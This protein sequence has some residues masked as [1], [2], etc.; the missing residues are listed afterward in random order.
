MKEKAGKCNSG[1]SVLALSP[2]RELAAQTA[3]VL[4]QL[5]PD[6]ALKGSLLAKATAAGSDFRKVDVLI[7]T[8]LLL[9]ES[10]TAKK[11][12]TG[13]RCCDRLCYTGMCM[14]RCC[15]EHAASA[16]TA[17]S[18]HY[19]PCRLLAAGTTRTFPCR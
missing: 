14:T 16:M 3:R 2:T 7:A 1:P 11:V 19:W 12:G 18:G 13:V 9:V 15:W 10:I 6:T 17:A 4:T 8:P 5:L